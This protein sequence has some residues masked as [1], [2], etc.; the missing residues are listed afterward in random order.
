MVFY[1]FLFTSQDYR[2][3]SEVGTLTYHTKVN[4]AVVI[5]VMVILVEADIRLKIANLLYWAIFTC[6]LMS[7][8][9]DTH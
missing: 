6:I 1:G 3:R 9:D 8:E 4:G 2:S 7:F 5:L